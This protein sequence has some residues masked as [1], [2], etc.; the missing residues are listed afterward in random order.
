MR[1]IAGV[2]MLIMLLFMCLSGCGSDRVVSNVG[3]TEEMSGSETGNISTGGKLTEQQLQILQSCGLGDSQ[4]QEIQEKGMSASQKSF[5]DVA[6]IVLNKLTKKYGIVFRILGGSIPDLLSSEYTFTVC[7]AEG[8]HALTPFEVTYGT[9]S[10]GEG[11]CRDGYFALIK[12][13]EM[14]EYLQSIADEEG[15]EIRVITHV[16]GQVD[17]AYTKEC[18][19]EDMKGEAAGIKVEIYGLVRAEVEE[20]DFIA[21]CERLAARYKETGYRMGYDVYRLL[22]GEQLTQI[23]GYEDLFRIYPQGMRKDVVYDIRYHEY[24]AGT[25]E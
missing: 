21:M 22:D 7:A 20:A 2:F 1:S 18:E 8:E 6:E 10:E 14:Q 13:Q 16:V 19:L 4:L 23:D 3:R 9:D 15:A 25:K 5:V 12:N 24:I 17:D 11:V